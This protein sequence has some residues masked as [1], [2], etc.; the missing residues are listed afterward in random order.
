MSPSWM[1]QLLTR[2]GADA[3][4]MQVN[5]VHTLLRALA[6][7]V[8]E[9]ES[10]PLQQALGRV[11]A[12]D[13]LSPVDVPPHDNAAMDGYA[14]AGQWLAT[15]EPLALPVAGT[16]LAGQPWTGDVPAG[17]ALRIMTG[18]MLPPGLDTVVPF[19]LC[20]LEDPADAA[21][22]TVRFA[23]AGLRPGANRRQRGEELATGATALPAGTRLGP[24]ELGLA[25]GLGLA[26]LTVRRRLRVALFSTG[27]ELLQPGEA[28]RTGAIYDS[29]RFALAA[30]LQQL[31]CT[32]HD[33]GAVRDE[34]AALRAALQHAAQDADVILTSG[35]VSS[36]D[37]DHT[38]T[39]LA[40]LGDVAFLRIAMRPGRP[41]AVGRMHRADGRPGA[42]LLGLPGNPV[43]TL[44]SFAL[45]ARPALLQ[46]MGMD[47]ERAT[48]A[49]VQ[50]PLAV[51]LRKRAGR[52]EFVR[53]TLH[54]NAQGQVEARPTG[55]QSSAMLSSL[56]QADA[57]LLLDHHQGDL[58]AATLVNALPLHGLL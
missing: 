18:A 53:A 14:F 26:Q 37:A 10:L 40:E 45:L 52:T 35:G 57:L 41:L 31:G 1:T 5:Q 43:A 11:L 47:A 48:P 15:A 2:I 7:P 54:T 4:A 46:A 42:L 49:L 24:A 36:G 27:D 9:T 23:S 56:V 29:N 25:A 12:A 39:L 30:A 33:L 3:G 58:A 6:E 28:A 51:P 32:V 34:P 38:Q 16:V 44:L 50:V 17:N 20:Q 55:N 13:V 22:P 21:V 8:A 19:E